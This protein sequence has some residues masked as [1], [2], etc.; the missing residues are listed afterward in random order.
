MR[1]HHVTFVIATYKRVEALKCTLQSIRLQDHSDWT[2]L[3]IGDCCGDE[4]YEMIRSLDETRIKYYNLPERFG[5]Q[6]GPNSVGLSLA[7]GDFITFLNHDD[8]LLRD[9]L[10]YSLDRMTAHGADFFIGESANA[11][12]LRF[13]DGGAAVPVF[14]EILPAQKD[15]SR[16]IHPNPYIFDP[17]SFWLVR[18]PYAKKV[19]PWRPASDLW[20]TPLRDWI[21]RAW[22]FGGKFSFGNRITGLR[23]WTQ[24]LRNGAPLYSNTTPEHDYMIER[25][26]TESPE[27]IR[28]YLHRQIEEACRQNTCSP[29]PGQRSHPLFGTT[30]I[31]GCLR[32]ILAEG[33]LRL[34]IDP[35]ILMDRLFRRPKGTLMNQISRKRTGE[36]LPQTQNISALLRNPEEYRMR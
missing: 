32:K 15:M 26:R 25:F 19:G 5:E 22:R 8:L 21:M 35:V 14:T 30:L 28:R 24:N 34:G 4:I 17:S 36:N 16:L 20:R 3:V 27:E 33:Y 7:T 12:S 2:A 29:K 10:V 11:T 18:T 9:H 6:S 31:K 1:S 23:F 13:D